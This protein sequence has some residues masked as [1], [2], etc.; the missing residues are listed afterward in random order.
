M[1]L[2]DHLRELRSRLTKSLIAILMG[3]VVGWIYHDPLFDLIR[4]PFDAVVAE[5]E[6][7]GRDMTLAFTG[8]ADPFVMQL[9]VA[10]VAGYCWPGWSPGSTTA[11]APAGPATSRSGTTTRCRRWTRS[12]R[13]LLHEPGDLATW[14]R[15][16]HRA[17]GGLSA[18][19][20]LG[21]A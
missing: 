20:S 15:G 8:V 2:T 4:T 16:P 21:Y 11:A 1:P 18:N 17:A 7:A 9:K 6:A 10:G 19:V 5:A 3:M 14:G 12:H 13:P